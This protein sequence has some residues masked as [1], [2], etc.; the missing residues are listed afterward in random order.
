MAKH[1]KKAKDIIGSFYIGVPVYG[2]K[3]VT[4][5]YDGDHWGRQTR[6]METM[7][8]P[9]RGVLVGG[10]YVPLGIKSYQGQEEGWCFLVTRKVFVFLVRESFLGKEIMVLPEDIR[11]D[12]SQKTNDLPILKTPMPE[13][14]K[15]ELS[16]I[17]SEWPRDEKGRWKKAELS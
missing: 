16:K 11:V 10:K 6:I 3:Q 8:K 7:I 5:D 2:E 17:M 1:K 9:F 4:F 15:R 14:Y 12:L 13:G